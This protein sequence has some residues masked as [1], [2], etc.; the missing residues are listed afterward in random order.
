MAI[1]AG[2]RKTP[3]LFERGVLRR[4]PTSLARNRGRGGKRTGKAARRF[5]RKCLPRRSWEQGGDA[6]RGRV[7]LL[8]ASAL[9]RRRSI[10]ARHGG[11]IPSNPVGASVLICQS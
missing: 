5:A 3:T 8:P 1:T 10:P 7:G 11:R 2:T 9:N 4:R 6:G